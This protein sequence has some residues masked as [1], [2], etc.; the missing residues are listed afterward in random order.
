[1]SQNDQRLLQDVGVP[2]ARYAQA[3]G[4]SR[5]AVSKGIRLEADYFS[6]HALSRILRNF[7][8]TDSSLYELA[9]ASVRSI[10]SRD[11]ERILSSMQGDMAPE[12]LDVSIPGEFTL[13][14]GDLYSFIRNSD[15]CHRQLTE[16]V[17][18]FDTSDGHLEFVVNKSD[19]RYLKTYYTL[20]KDRRKISELRCNYDLSLFPTYLLRIAPDMTIVLFGCTRNGFVSISGFEVNRIRRTIQRLGSAE[21]VSGLDKGN[22]EVEF[23]AQ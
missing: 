8:D 20:C 6:P 10:Y 7:Q 1:L 5:Q 16:I 14:T 19:L 15:E 12:Q 18:L 11:A 17:S 23:T 3:L 21:S 9:K 2:I 13:V 22:G 4:V